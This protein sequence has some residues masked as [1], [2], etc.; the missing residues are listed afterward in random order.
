MTR[1]ELAR[2]LRVG[3]LYLQKKW[4]HIVEQKAKQGIEL[5]KCGRGDSANYGIRFPWQ[6]SLVFEYGLDKIR[7]IL[8]SIGIE[9]EMDYYIEE[10]DLTF[11]FYISDVDVMLDWCGYSEAKVKW[12]EAN[13][14]QYVNISAGDEINENI[15]EEKIYG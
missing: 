15:I 4:A 8:D 13:G 9:Y 11:D 14:F 1:K 6:K 7:D 2:T 3:E 12:C 5:C 10:I